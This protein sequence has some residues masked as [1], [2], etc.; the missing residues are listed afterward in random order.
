M[1]RSCGR[2][3]YGDSDASFVYGDSDDKFAC[4]LFEVVHECVGVDVQ[5]CAGGALTDA[6]AAFALCRRSIL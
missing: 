1:C 3:E 5:W 4:W 2:E 6:K